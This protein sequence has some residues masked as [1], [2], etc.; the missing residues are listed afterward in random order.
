M[1]LQFK[2]NIVLNFSQ[3]LI[4][5]LNEQIIFMYIKIKSV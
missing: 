1:M 2:F 4:V 5:I 3:S